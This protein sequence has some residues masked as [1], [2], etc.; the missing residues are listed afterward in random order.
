VG[1]SLCAE[2]VAQLQ[3]IP[4]VSGVHLMAFAW[5]ESVPEILS[6]AGIPARQRSN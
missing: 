1:L 4:G 2:M 5:E 3:S 6:R